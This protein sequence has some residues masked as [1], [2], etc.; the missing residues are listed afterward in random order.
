[1]LV[2][3]QQILKQKLKIAFLSLFGDWLLVK[4]AA[5]HNGWRKE[6]EVIR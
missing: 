1:M 5:V 3:L 6:D 4:L 2:Y